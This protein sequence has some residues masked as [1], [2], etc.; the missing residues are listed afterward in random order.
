PR[1]KAGIP[2]GPLRALSSTRPPL[3]EGGLQQR[4]ALPLS[5]ACEDVGR[6]PGMKPD[7]HFTVRP[8]RRLPLASGVEG[9]SDSPSTQPLRGYAQDEREFFA[10]RMKLT[11]WPKI[12]SVGGGARRKRPEG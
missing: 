10:F 12:P 11:D 6:L 5:R 7:F 2:A 4:V 1:K 8:E 3:S 9:L